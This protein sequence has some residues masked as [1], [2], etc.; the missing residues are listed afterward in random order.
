[1]NEKKRDVELKPEVVEALR[2]IVGPQNISIDLGIRRSYTLQ[3]LSSLLGATSKYVDSVPSAIVLPGTTEE[4]QAIVKLCNRFGIQY[5]AH[6]TG[7]GAH[8]ITKFAGP[9][10][11]DMV[12]MNRIVEIDD[13]NMYAIIEPYVWGR[14]LQA[15]LMKRGLFCHIIGAGS[16][17]SPLASCTAG[18]GYGPTSSSMGANYRNL[19]GWE[20]VTPIG[21][22]VRQGPCDG[23]RFGARGPDVRGIFKGFLGSAGGLGVFTQAAI[24]V[25]PW[26][27]PPVLEVTGK[28]PQ[29]GW[30]IPENMKLY[31]VCFPNDHEWK[32]FSHAV[33]ELGFEELCYAETNSPLVKW[34]MFIS[35]TNHE[36]REMWLKLEENNEVGK[37]LYPLHFIITWETE[38]ERQ[39]KEKV[40][41]EILAEAGAIEFLPQ[42]IGEEEKNI[43]FTNCL[44]YYM[45]GRN[46]RMGGG[47]MGTSMGYPADVDTCLAGAIL[48]TKLKEPYIQQGRIVADG[49][50][51]FTMW[52]QEDA[53]IAHSEGIFFFDGMN[54]EDVKAAGQLVMETVQTE[55]NEKLLGAGLL[56]G[57]APD[58]SKMLNPLQSRYFDWTQKIKDAFD[59]QR[60]AESCAYTGEP[61]SAYAEKPATPSVSASEDKSGSDS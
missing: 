48:G 21:E 45:S 32:R 39:Y 59:P 34:M 16:Q 18:W 38:E 9:I 12:R 22:I 42:F 3:I 10:I 31:G 50:Q 17:C 40:V 46:F 2:T 7:W 51:T 20:W 33:Y 14:D 56:L 8:T 57:M 27:G 37:Y 58:F 15:E 26:P 13:R 11:L 30:K 23:R 35:P 25:H 52:P 43:C 29:Y 61:A 36:W 44:T 41:D 53:R 28:R 4:V 6:S 47:D 24:N 55:A 49:V 19:I 1:M 5:K 60:L 54:P